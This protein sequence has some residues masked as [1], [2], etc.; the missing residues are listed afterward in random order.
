[1]LTSLKK[2]STII[3]LLLVLLLFV[4]A[5]FYPSL[6]LILGTILLVLTLAVACIS[7]VK[8]H[9]KSYLQ[10]EIT[11]LIFLRNVTLE[12]SGILVATAF[13]AYIGNYMALIATQSIND[14]LIRFAIGVF[15]GLLIGIAIGTLV[16]KFWNRYLLQQI[17]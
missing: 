7:V 16:R 1:M 2:Y 6:G 12:I 3:S 4:V 8:K 14:V 5:W 15:V 9:R 10:G 17:K 11:Y 13:A